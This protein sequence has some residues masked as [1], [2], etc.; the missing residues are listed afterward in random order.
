MKNINSE[1]HYTLEELKNEFKDV[2]KAAEQIEEKAD[3]FNA[4]HYSKGHVAASFTST[5]M[6]I[7]TTN[8]VAVLDK[9]VVRYARV[10]KKGYVRLVTN[11]GSLNLELFCNLVP[12]T[13]ENFLKLCQNSYFNN[14]KFHR[15]VRNFMIQGGDPTGSGKGGK[16]VWG[17]KFDDEFHPSL[18]HTGRGI[19]SM[20]TLGLIQ[21]ARNCTRNLTFF[22]L[23]NLI[24]GD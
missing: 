7:Q 22:L 6:Q 8:E 1:T 3:E 23:F 2:K 20:A 9:D 11:Y 24:L 14:T 10:K 13:C 19:L 18:S 21:M 16:S 4:A 12:K 15:S 5:V 17:N